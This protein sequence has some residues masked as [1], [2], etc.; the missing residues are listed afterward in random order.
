MAT[1]TLEEAESQLSTVNIAISQLI[2]GKRIQQLKIGS[3]EFARLLTYEQVTLND[4]T[5]LQSELRSII[6]ALSPA[7]TPVFRTNACIPLETRK[8]NG[9]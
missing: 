9:C 5:T 7:V 6:A 8:R 4:L 1:M 3:G 2:A